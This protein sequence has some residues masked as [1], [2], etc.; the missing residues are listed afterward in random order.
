MKKYLLLVL[1]VL[2]GCQS[3]RDSVSDYNPPLE[4][5]NPVFNLTMQLQGKIIRDYRITPTDYIDLGSEDFSEKCQY[6]TEDNKAV[7]IKC[8]SESDQTYNMFISRYRSDEYCSIKGCSFRV[9]EGSPIEIY[10][11]SFVAE[12]FNC[13]K[14]GGEEAVKACK[15]KYCSD[16]LSRRELWKIN[17]NTDPIFIDCYYELKARGWDKYITDGKWEEINPND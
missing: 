5:K 9:S 4:F 16:E 6:I 11:S 17:G 3:D 8:G 1:L 7:F 13:D 2:T 12:S 14:E 15:I 10:S